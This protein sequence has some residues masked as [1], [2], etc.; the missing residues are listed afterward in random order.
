MTDL[1]ATY[2]EGGSAPLFVHL[3]DIHFDAISTTIKGPNQLVREALL[4]DLEAAR[5]EVGRPQAVLVTG[6]IAFSG[7]KREYEQAREF[8]RLVTDRLGIE[9]EQ[10]QT[11]PGNHDVDRNQVVGSIKASRDMLRALSPLEADKALRDYLEEDRTDPLFAPLG[12]YREFA[13]AY[14]CAVSGRAPFWEVDWP[15]GISHVLR[16]RGLTTVMVSDGGDHKANLIVGSDQTTLATAAR[17]DVVM[18]LGH[19]PPDW[20][21]DQDD[22]ETYM[23]G[24]AS[25]HLYGHKHRHR[26][27]TVDASVRLVAGA[28]HPEREMD[29]EPRYNWLRLNLQGEGTESPQLRVEVWPRVLSIGENRFRSGG[30]GGRWHPDERTVPL[31]RLARA[32][33]APTEPDPAPEP[34]RPTQHA[35]AV[36]VAARREPVTDAS[37][38]PTPLRRAVYRFGR[39]GYKTQTA[40]LSELGLI[41]D[42]DRDLPAEEK[43]RAAFSRARQNGRVDELVA[44]IDAA[45]EPGGD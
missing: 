7:K 36:L 22:A 29:W 44:R 16:V 23:T 14:G 21:H 24:Y 26:L 43:L 8:L 3:S 4:D 11:V 28:V 13:L 40:I 12:E 6:D 33:A 31:R 42:E 34:Q 45:G 2:P 5:R 17:N 41:E 9:P 27:S 37:G 1:T 18:V 38:K 32:P 35:A 15:L 30:E 19:H 39:L 25:V 20:W 10:V